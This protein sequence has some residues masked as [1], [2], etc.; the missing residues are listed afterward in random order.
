MESPKVQKVSHWLSKDTKHGHKLKRRVYLFEGPSFGNPPF[1]RFRRCKSF[2]LDGPPKIGG[3]NPQN[4]WF[5]MVPKPY[6]QMDDLGGP[7]L[8]LETPIW[9]LTVFHHILTSRKHHITPSHGFPRCPRH[10]FGTVQHLCLVMMSENRGE[11]SLED[12][13]S[14]HTWKINILNS[15]LTLTNQEFM[16]PWKDYHLTQ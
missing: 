14:V 16:T 8:V 6:E 12:L 7:P 5:R 2:H 15:T 1:V 3:F 13:E 10:N 9:H 4:G 11:G